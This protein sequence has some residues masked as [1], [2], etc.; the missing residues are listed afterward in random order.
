M[1]DRGG[2]PVFVVA[3]GFHLDTRSEPHSHKGLDAF[4]RPLLG[5][6]ADQLAPQIEALTGI[7]SRS[8]A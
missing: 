8:M 3:E 2:A 4:N 6:I 5:G 7:E 1:R